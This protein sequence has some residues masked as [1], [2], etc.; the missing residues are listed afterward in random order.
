MHKVMTRPRSRPAITRPP[1]RKDPRRPTAQTRPPRTAP[2]PPPH[3]TELFTERLLL[4]LSGQKPV[5]WAARHI[6]N[7]AFDDLARL[8]EHTPL[9]V[10]GRRPTIH[11][12][13]HYEPSPGVYEVFARIGTGPALRA[14]AFRLHLGADQRWRCTAVEVAAPGRS[15]SR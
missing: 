3:P 15:R 7:T 10:D 1:G 11:R 6:A 12:I 8:A 2:Q 9:N 14:L 4:V 5:H 13:G